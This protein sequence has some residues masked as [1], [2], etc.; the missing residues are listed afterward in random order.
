MPINT[1]LLSLGILVL[2]NSSLVLVIKYY[3]N[4]ASSSSGNVVVMA[5]IIKLIASFVLYAIETFKGPFQIIQDLQINWIQMSVPAIL[6]LLQNNLQFLAV[7][8]LDA[9]TFQVLHQMKI[10]TTAIFSVLLLGKVLL[11]RQWLSLLTLTIG[12]GLVQISNLKVKISGQERGFIYIVIVCILSGIAGV[13][14]EMVLKGSKA[15]LF[16]RNIQLSLF[17]I[18]FGFGFGLYDSD[19]FNIANYDMWAWITI[20]N[21]AFAGL[22]VAMVVK[23]ADNILKG[24]ATSI[25]IIISSVASIFI[26]DFQITHMFLIGASLV[27]LGNYRFNGVATY[28]Y[29]IGQVA[30]KINSE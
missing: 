19:A 28:N 21:Q 12:V 1:K 14:F 30:I 4:N 27:L 2:Q 17:G 9:A 15:S 10:L 3:S 25:S 13:W 16:L 7:G 22:I 18:L 8:L 23:Y 20:L 24:F 11:Y 5:E 26:F 6:Y 29:S